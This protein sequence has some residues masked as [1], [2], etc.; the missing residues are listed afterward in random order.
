[1]FVNPDQTGIHKI[2]TDTVTIAV[3]GLSAD[4]AKASHRVAKYLMEHG[5]NIIPVNPT[6]QDV[7]GEKCYPSL[8][9][10]PQ[11]VD[12]VD[13]FRKAEEVPAIVAS[14]IKN[15]VPVIWIQEGISCPIAAIEAEEAGL[16][17]VMDL[18]IM[19][20]HNKLCR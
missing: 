19:K 10:I 16:K 12:M 15:K 6:L 1:M 2:L 11:P 14:A 18:C 7:L 4:P 8:E 3:V 13:V 17:V 5:Y 9:D 20:M